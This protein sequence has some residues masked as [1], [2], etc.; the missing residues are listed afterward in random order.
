[1][2]WRQHESFIKL[3]DQGTNATE[4]LCARACCEVGLCE[5]IGLA[6]PHNLEICTSNGHGV[7]TGAVA[8]EEHVVIA[9]L[10]GLHRVA[11]RQLRSHVSRLH[12]R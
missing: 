8:E 7:S 3:R 12:S 2:N 9:P 1:M 10:C 4:I 5:R 6:A 11:A